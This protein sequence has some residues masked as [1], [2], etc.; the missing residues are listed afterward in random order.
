MSD[1]NKDTHISNLNARVTGVETRIDAHGDQLTQIQHTLSKINTSLNKVG[2]AN[3]ALYVAIISTALAFMTIVAV[4]G[5][6]AI[7]PLKETITR[8]ER[9]VEAVRTETKE[10][11]YREI[12]NIN[13]IKRGR[14]VE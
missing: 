5:N 10:L 2:K 1:T 4:I 6:L 8:N 3:P 13:L 7:A 14:T 12:D 9:K 11:I